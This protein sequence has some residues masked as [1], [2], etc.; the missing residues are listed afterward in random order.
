[1][2][3]EKQTISKGDV[4][5]V[6]AVDLLPAK[7]SAVGLLTRVATQGFAVPK[8]KTPLASMSENK[9]LPRFQ[10]YGKNSLA[11]IE[12]R[13]ESDQ[14]GINQGMKRD[15]PLGLDVPFWPISYRRMALDL[16]D[17]KNIV[18]C[19]DINDP[20]FKELMERPKPPGGGMSGA[21]WGVDYLVWVP[22]YKGVGTFASFFANNA[23]AR[24]SAQDLEPI[25]QTHSFAKAGKRF[26]DTGAYKYWGPNFVPYT[27]EMQLPDQDFT[28]KMVEKFLDEA[29]KGTRTFSEEDEVAEA[30]GS[31]RER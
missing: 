27:G 9:F 11:V 7:E 5:T 26:I 25:I 10:F 30:T 21:L 17:K 12:N 16:A 19:F 8:P 22:G 4:A 2:P 28:I 24:I 23:T 31:S 29:E 18:Q 1:M 15:F 13:L 3:T 14:W 6:K 20:I